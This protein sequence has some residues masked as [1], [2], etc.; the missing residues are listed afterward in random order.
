MHQYAFLV[1]DDTFDAIHGRILEGGISHR[2][3]PQMALPSQITSNHDGCGF[4]FKGPTGHGMQVITRPY[5]P[6]G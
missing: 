4:Y 2:A 1:E 5:G 6:A 3:D